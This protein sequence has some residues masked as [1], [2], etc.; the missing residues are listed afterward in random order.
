M[1]IETSTMTRFRSVILFLLLFAPACFAQ[2][3]PTVAA[4]AN[5][6]FA[7]DKIQQQ[8]EHDT[9]KQVRISY[10][11]SGQLMQQ[12]KH[13]APFEIFLSANVDYAQKIVEA[14]LAPPPA[15]VYAIGRLAIMHNKHVK[16]PLSSDLAYLK[17]ELQQGKIQRFAIANPD[18]AP[19]GARAKDVLQ[20]IGVWQQIQPKLLYGE[21]VAQAAQFALSNASQGGIVALSLT[22]AK[23]FSNKANVVAIDAKLHP[24]LT[25]AMVLLNNASDTAKAFYAYLQSPKAQQTLVDFGFDLPK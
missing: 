2:D 8:F 9:G 7:L 20:A 25:Q 22:K 18:H 12:I 10:G 3:I 5:V 16:L 1:T 6:R 11:S 4:A 19:Y 24:K 21:N 17:Q 13:G 14:K 23:G 15:K